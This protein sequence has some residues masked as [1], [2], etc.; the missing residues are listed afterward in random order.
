[1]RAMCFPVPTYPI[2]HSLVENKYVTVFGV[3]SSNLEG[4]E[5]ALINPDFLDSGIP[6]FK[7]SYTGPRSVVNRH[8][9]QGRPFIDFNKEGFLK[10]YT[11]TTN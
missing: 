8:Y 6:I 9:C 3:P 7:P 11:E 1:M 5:F 2:G 4:G 10:Y